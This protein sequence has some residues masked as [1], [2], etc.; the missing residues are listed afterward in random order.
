VA[1]AIGCAV[2]IAGCGSS[3]NKPSHS[4]SGGSFVAFS[5]CMRSHGVPNFP[6]PTGGGG[7]HLDGTNIN[8]ASPSFLA[9]REICRKK[10][11]GGGPGA[12]SA[13]EK[14]RFK[15]QLVA[16]A[17]CMRSHGVTGF[18]DPFIGSPPSDPAGY[19]ILEDEGGVVLAVPATINPSSPLF[20]RAAKSCSF[21]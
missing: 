4:G 3:G 5:V 14:A 10:L 15:V 1:A 12:V 2:A 7:I 11:P 17:A 9:A 20:T 6:D 13:A 21:S 8:P 19:S 18:P 16:A